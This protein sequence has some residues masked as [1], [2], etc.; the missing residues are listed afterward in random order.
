MFFTTCGSRNPLTLGSLENPRTAKAHILL[1]CH[2]QTYYMS[3]GL[4]DH[5]P[6]SAKTTYVY[7]IRPQQLFSELR[8]NCDGLGGAVSRWDGGCCSL[9]H[10]AP[11]CESRIQYVAYAFSANTRVSWTYL[12]LIPI[13]TTFQIHIHPPYAPALVPARNAFEFPRELFVLILSFVLSAPT[14]TP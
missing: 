6:A 1:G 8:D 2:I 3:S 9:L 14:F 5:R 10:A 11:T 12:C 7:E 13:F 4:P